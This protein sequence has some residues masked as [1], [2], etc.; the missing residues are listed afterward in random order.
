MDINISKLFK[1]NIFV[2]DMLRKNLFRNYNNKMQSFISHISKVDS[3]GDFA[4]FREEIKLCPSNIYGS[5]YTIKRAFAENTSYGYA[6]SLMKYA[7][8]PNENILYLP[9]LEHGI[10][11]A[12]YIDFNRYNRY[13]SYIFQ[14]RS[15]EKLW[16]EREDYRPIYYVGPYIHYVDQYY[17]KD[18]IDS[19]RSEN[20]NSLLIFPPHSTEFEELSLDFTSFNNYLFNEVGNKHKTL[21][22][23]IF[24]KDIDDSYTKYLESMGVKLVS[25]GF[26]LDSFFANRLK[27][28]LSLADT[29]VYPSF[30]SSIGYAYY[31]GKRIIYMD[32]E[33]NID[34]SSNYGSERWKT[35]KDNYSTIKD[36]FAHAFSEGTDIK[37]NEKDKIIERFWGINEIK[38]PEEIRNIYFENKKYVRKRLGF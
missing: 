30:S 29:I 5:A 8:L 32:N 23:C 35:I 14:G 12:N 19:I 33:D 2:N 3:I 20:G 27:T 15:K 34:Y 17:D 26:R 38:T 24:W 1:K 37:N 11:L 25:A 16:R 21:Y 4:N 18:K 28:I 13:M 9:L 6:E 10:Y 36:M 22:A 7:N 31:L